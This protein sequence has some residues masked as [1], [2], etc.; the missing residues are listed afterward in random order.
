MSALTPQ[1]RFGNIQGVESVSFSLSRGVQ[2]SVCT[3]SMPLNI[4]GL[5]RK[6]KTMYF[7]DGI[8]TVQFAD[9]IIS[10]V[11]P[12]VDGEGF[13][14]MSI[15]ILDRRWK[16]GFGHISGTYNIR[17][18]GQIKAATKKTPRELATLIFE[19]MGDKKFDVSKMPNDTFPFIDWDL[20]TPA[21][22]LQ[23]LCDSVGAHVCLGHDDVARVFRD[24]EGQEIPN[25]PSSS[26]GKGFD[27]G[28]QP[29]KVGIATGNMQWEFDFPLVPV[30]LDVDAKIKSIYELSYMPSGGWGGCTPPFM[31]SVNG[32]I[33]R[34]TGRPKSLGNQLKLA[35]E[36]VWRWFKIDKPYNLSKMPLTD[37]KLETVDQLF[38]LLDYQL[39]YEEISTVQKVSL[40]DT[41]YDPEN[42]N[43]KPQLVWG[44]FYDESGTG[45]DNTVEL[46]GSGDDAKPFNYPVGVDLSKFKED[47][48]GKRDVILKAL[49]YPKGFT[50]DQDRQLVI[51]SDP[52]YRIISGDFYLP[53]LWLRTSCN[54]RNLKTRAPYRK[55]MLKAVPNAPD[56]KLVEWTE[57]EE[58]VP[59][60]YKRDGKDYNNLKSVED[61]L[62]YYIQYAL[63]K[64][65]SRTPAHADIPYLLPFSPDGKIA[66]VIFSIDGEGFISTQINKELEAL[67]TPVSYQE[68]KRLV[69]E[70]ETSKQLAR[71]NQKQDPKQGKQ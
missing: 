36:T 57:R 29:G 63:D 50:I 68:R 48:T 39:E 14:V 8:R 25:V 26:F 62:N 20:K 17:S 33:D 22:A 49:I 71:S 40:G 19:A 35:R 15:A 64:Y 10:D 31:S 37:E 23:E 51:F 2:P 46:L 6:P 1:F 45:D 60:W 18:A 13:Q 27:F 5:D 24:G 12:D 54:F 43:R 56:S 4:E 3:V 47:A 67:S 59:S 69:R 38:P 58:L 53:R 55:N 61:S 52:V 32:G 9:C 70:Y 21:S 7:S 11:S 30:G 44:Q 28:A 66:Q 41:A 16:W 42:L 65:R 34:V